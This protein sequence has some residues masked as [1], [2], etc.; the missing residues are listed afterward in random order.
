MTVLGFD[1]STAAI[2]VGLL[3]PNGQTFEHMPQPSRLQ[4]RP[5]HAAELMPA[6]EAVLEEGGVPYED[7]GAIGVGVGPG[8]FTGL[9]IGV[10][11]A[12]ALAHA[13]GAELRPVSSLAALAHGIDAPLRLPLIDARRGELFAALYEGE[14]EL[15][16]PF[17]A[18]PEALAERIR[19]AGL[20]PRAAGDGSVRFRGVLEA[21]GVEVEPDGSGAHVIHGLQVC[22]LARTA[23]A[24]PPER[25]VPHYLRAPDAKPNQ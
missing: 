19:N 23:P 6:V 25:V 9:R 18:T 17:A 24:V 21:A 16:E 7:I 13:T 12:R 22:W 14:D 1:T 2:S 5:A 8:G 10:S 4:E 11:T 20:T 3:K 15:W